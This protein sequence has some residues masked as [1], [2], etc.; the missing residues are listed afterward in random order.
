[1][2]A[3]TRVFSFLGGAAGPWRVT[4]TRTVTGASLPVASRLEIA[5]GKVPASSADWCLQGAI[6]N[7]RYVTRAESDRLAAV[8]ATLGRSEAVQATLIPIRKNAAWW[9][10][11]Q[12]ERRHILEESSRHIVIGMEYL[13][14][15]ARRLYHCRDL[16][17]AQPFDFLTWFEF[18]PAHVSAFDELL[19]RLRKTP[20]WSYVDRELEISLLR[21]S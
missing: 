1:M 4:Q 19:A 12:D 10:L 8:Q 7:T 6:S 13:P 9:A 16:D 14:A 20:E 3:N 11:A 17:Q 5:A 2:E 21:E 15:V 18:S